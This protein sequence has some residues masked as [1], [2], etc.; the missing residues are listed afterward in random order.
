MQTEVAEVGQVSDPNRTIAQSID[1]YLLL[2]RSQG[3]SE[4]TLELDQWRAGIVVRGLGRIKL[5]ALT[6][7]QSDAFLRRAAAG[8]FSP[9]P[10]DGGQIATDQLR[11]VRGFLARAVRND[12]RLGLV[13]RNVVELS[14]LPVLDTETR[15]RRALE[16]EEMT[17]LLDGASG[18]FAVLVELMGRYGLRPAE[19]RA[20]LW[21]AV[22]F[23]SAEISVGPRLN[24]RNQRIGPKTPEADRILKLGPD[25][26]AR[27]EQWQAKQSEL[28][29]VAGAAWT[30][31]GLVATTGVGTAVGFRNLQRSLTDLSVDLEIAPAAAAYE[32][33]HT[34]ITR[35]CEA[36]Y[37]TREIADW[38]GTSERMIIEVYRHKLGGA[39]PLGP[40]S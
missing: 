19:S 5:Q 10:G 7:A 32:L 17:M 9:R 37:T 11:R 26:V 20:V 25:T 23:D 16:P 2:R 18:A 30:D 8:E 1:D 36:G 4:R 21:E 27:L 22:R 40:A 33:R 24:R 6:V 31:H 39:S 29:A 34:A 14:E 28:R 3:W 38:A 15:P 12:M 13:G 35:Q